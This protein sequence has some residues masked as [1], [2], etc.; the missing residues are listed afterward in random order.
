MRWPDKSKVRDAVVDELTQVM[1]RMAE[2]AQRTREGA[3]HEQAKPEND[4][5]TRALEQSYLARGQA[6]RVES[7]AEEIQALRSLALP[8][9]RDGDTIQIGTLVAVEVDEE[10]RVLWLAPHAGGTE[11]QVDGVRVLVVTGGSPLGRAL[12]ERSVG[13]DFSLQLR[14][15]AREHA[16][17]AAR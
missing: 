7:L 9:Y 8:E 5:D 1:K 14:G 3:T 6:M 17:I 12:L 10:P 13:D 2:S 11:V 16:I 15:I 4:K